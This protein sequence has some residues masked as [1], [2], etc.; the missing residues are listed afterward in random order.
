MIIERRGRHY[1]AKQERDSV[2]CHHKAE[3]DTMANRYYAEVK[4]GG[5]ITAEQH[6]RILELLEQEADDSCDSEMNGAVLSVWKNDSTSDAYGEVDH[7]GNSPHGEFPRL[8]EYLDAQGIPYNIVCDPPE[9]SYAI[10]AHRP[11]KETEWCYCTEDGDLTPKLADLRKKAAERGL[12]LEQI[13]D[14]MGATFALPTLFIG[15]VASGKFSR[16]FD[17][18]GGHI[19]TYDVKDSE[20]VGCT[21]RGYSEGEEETVLTAEA[22]WQDASGVPLS[23]NTEAGRDLLNVLDAEW[24]SDARP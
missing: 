18:G 5:E 2:Y 4:I 10:E 1:S 20:V 12:T 16:V 21:E 17:A 23:V 13:S 3:E 15:G 24:Q 6:E 22:H 19:V 8:Q 14:E 7:K 11:P 9:D